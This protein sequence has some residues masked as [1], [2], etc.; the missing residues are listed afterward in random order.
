[1]AESV[2]EVICS[3]ASLVFTNRPAGQSKAVFLSS[4]KQKQKQNEKDNCNKDTHS[5]YTYIHCQQ[6]NCHVITSLQEKG[7]NRRAVNATLPTEIIA[8]NYYIAH[9]R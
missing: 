4:H 3:L 1:M 7:A 2:A 6:I 8:Q 5:A 9:K